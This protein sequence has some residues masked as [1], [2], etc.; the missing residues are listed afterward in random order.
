LNIAIFM[1]GD[2]PERDV[3]LETGRCV[4]RALLELEHQILP[5]DP[6]R[7]GEPLAEDINSWGSGPAPQPP[8]LIP[9]GGR[10]HGALFS[11]VQ[12]CRQHG[13]D[14]IFNALHGG[15]GEDGTIQGYLDLVGIPYTGSGMLASALAMDKTMAKKIFDREGIRVP[16]GITLPA[17]AAQDANRLLNMSA[18]A[19]MLPVVVKPNSQG[20]TVGLRLV[21]EK[22][23]L[24]EACQEADRY[25]SG[26]LVEE[27]IPGR[28]LTVALLEDRALPLVEIVP[29]GG[30][31][32][33]THKYTDGKSQ[34][35]TNP[36]L[37]SEL[38]G[39]IQAM[40]LKAFQALGCY[41]YARADLRLSPEN[42][43][44]L[45]EINTLPGMTP[46]SL[47]PKAAQAA[48]IDFAHLVQRII[49]LALERR[50]SQR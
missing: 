16:N 32:D 14:V 7:G 9:Q 25:G 46:H 33:Y 41:G 44:Y 6:S 48:G 23:Q 19:L 45:L 1:G 40:S 5:L 29:E 31:Y 13:A 2:T 39:E 28:E 15:I 38:T 20:S 30:L 4:A 35:I 3:S 42:I 21:E 50:S 11:A 36:D 43:P 27:Y 17:T 18:P 22:A 47:V 12:A 34:Y 8:E 37:P 49:N 26:V 10:Y 24:S